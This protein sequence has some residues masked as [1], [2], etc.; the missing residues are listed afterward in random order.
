M[1]IIDAWINS[2]GGFQDS[3]TTHINNS[4]IKQQNYNI[5]SDEMKL[6]IT[7]FTWGP[8]QVKDQSTT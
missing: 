7:I 8:T 1:V 4:T 6:F 3:N 5:N 2:M